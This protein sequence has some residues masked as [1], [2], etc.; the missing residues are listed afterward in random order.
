MREI[1]VRA[2][3]T[4]ANFG[5]GFDIFALALEKPY[6]EFRISL[7]QNNFVVINIEAG[8][9]EVPTEVKRNTAGLAAINLLQR[10][11]KS[12]GVEINIKKG[13]KTCS[14]LG[15]SGASAS[16]TVYGLNQMLSLNLN[17][18]E[19]IEIASS[20]ERIT[21]GQ[22]HA[23]NAAACL[24][25]GFILV[26]CYNP[27]D[28]TK[29]EVSDIPIVIS[30][31]KKKLITTRGLIKKRYTL[32]ELKNQISCCSALIH[33]IESGNLKD[34]GRFVNKDCLSEPARAKSIPGYENVKRR[35]L[36]AGAYGCNISG[37][38]SSI[39]AICEKE[40][41]EE[42]ATIFEK[43]LIETEK[44]ILITKS[45]NIGITQI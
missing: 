12:Q 4:I 40:K 22:P 19:I 41:R 33:A 39:F 14:G 37:G 1:V 18:T 3:A 34:I 11:G 6:D 7:S 43:E 23:D 25:G 8:K 13:I 30:I 45:S 31:I 16:A 24:L 9:W 20:A 36:D 29:F 32:K 5:P 35:V 26:R 2:P 27:M 17:Y 21:G 28:V 15:S 42:I 38:G 44:E 10:L